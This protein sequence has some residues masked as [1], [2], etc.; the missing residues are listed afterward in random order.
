M[1]CPLW[2]QTTRRNCDSANKIHKKEWREKS[3]WLDLRGA[4]LDLNLFNAEKN[5]PKNSF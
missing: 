3:V 4:Q 2:P 5:P 1:D